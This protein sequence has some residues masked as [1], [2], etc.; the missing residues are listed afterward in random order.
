MLTRGRSLSDGAVDL[1]YIEKG[2]PKSKLVKLFLDLE[3]GT[4]IENSPDCV[5]YVK[6]RAFA[7]VPKQEGIM[8]ADGEVINN[9]PLICEVHPGIGRVIAPSYLSKHVPEA[10]WEGSRKQELAIQRKK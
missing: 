6:A 10:A 4:A 2:I 3:D 1:I 7:L 8:D 9:E 5:K